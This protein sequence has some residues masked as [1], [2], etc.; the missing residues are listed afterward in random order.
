MARESVWRRPNRRFIATGL[1]VVLCFYVPLN[2]SGRFPDLRVSHLRSL[3]SHITEETELT[4]S[5]KTAHIEQLTFP[6]NDPRITEFVEREFYGWD[7]MS[8]HGHYVYITASDWEEVL[9]A[10]IDLPAGTAEIRYRR[11]A[12]DTLFD[13]L[14]GFFA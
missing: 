8:S 9:Y 2:C 4:E 1:I 3:A 11:N 12:K 7:N 6:P 5:G 14:R 13:A 10:D